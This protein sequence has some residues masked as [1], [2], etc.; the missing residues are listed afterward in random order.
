MTMIHTC[1]WPGCEIAVHPR[2]WGCRPH[3][4]QIPQPLQRRIW[5]TYRLGQEKTKDPSK[6]Y[7]EAAMAVQRWI[8][9]NAI[10]R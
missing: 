6:E 5:A 10:V 1:H 9:E 3:W 8:R 7:I 2:F 4:N